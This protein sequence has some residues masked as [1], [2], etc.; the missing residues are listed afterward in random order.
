[1]FIH[2]S[3][4]AN[5]DARYWHA[6]VLVTNVPKVRD[7]FIK[8]RACQAKVG[9]CKLCA[10]TQKQM[11]TSVLVLLL[12]LL[13]ATSAQWQQGSLPTSFS[14]IFL[15][16]EGF[17]R[18]P[19]RGATHYYKT[20]WDAQTFEFCSRAGV[21]N[22][23]CVDYFCNNST[24]PATSMTMEQQQ[25]Q[26]AMLNNY[27]QYCEFGTV[28]SKDQF[29]QFHNLVS[30]GS[31]ARF[32]QYDNFSCG[33][34]N[35]PWLN[36]R[37]LAVNQ[38]TLQKFKGTPY[39]C[40]CSQLNKLGSECGAMTA[41]FDDLLHEGFFIFNMVFGMISMILIIVCIMIPECG[42]KHR[43]ATTHGH[44]FK[45]RCMS[46]ASIRMQSIY[47]LFASLLL[48]VVDNAVEMAV[49]STH[50][51]VILSAMPNAVFYIFS[52]MLLFASYATMLIL[53]YVIHALVLTCNR[54][55]VY[56]KANE[57]S[58]DSSLD[59]KHMYVCKQF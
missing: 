38:S 52:L 47:L 17:M 24:I 16:T 2:A 41:F 13:Q 59:R 25:Q 7:F 39:L 14:T 31:C 6:L 56:T 44:A 11:P 54:S 51:L 45:E 42:I 40:Y 21:Q 15:K 53:W 55:S 35:W 46:L 8:Y 48:F 5:D 32:V 23:S 30:N 19:A 1:M 29:L 33:A 3:V 37:A 27:C 49:F 57:G 9:I 50:S 4:W 43:E 36:H 20:P 34:G 58:T 10:N 18:E 22:I 28:R 12:L 26:Y